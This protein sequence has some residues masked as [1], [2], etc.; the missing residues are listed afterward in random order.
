[1][2]NVLALSYNHPLSIFDAIHNFA[3]HHIWHQSCGIPQLT[4]SAFLRR[5]LNPWTASGFTLTLQLR[6]CRGFYHPGIT[7]WWPILVVQ[8]VSGAASWLSSSPRERW[9]W[10]GAGLPGGGEHLAGCRGIKGRGGI[11]ESPLM[12]RKGKKIWYLS[13]HFLRIANFE[14]RILAHVSTHS[15]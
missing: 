8:H 2:E 11:P 7:R 15:E 3:E 6:H 12:S 13:F 1:M 5:W 9:R 4:N 14:S 10:G